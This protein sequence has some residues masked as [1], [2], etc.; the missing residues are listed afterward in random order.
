MQF[1]G[2]SDIRTSDSP[3][4]TPHANSSVDQLLEHLRSAQE[5]EEKLGH[6]VTPALPNIADYWRPE[7]LAANDNLDATYHHGPPVMDKPASSKPSVTTDAGDA[8]A[9]D[10]AGSV[11]PEMVSGDVPAAAGMNG[12]RVRVGEVLPATAV[13]VEVPIAGR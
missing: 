11:H 10:F 6:P 3:T 7:L 2:C 4:K 8:S 12:E 9:G 5:A 1:W 13:P